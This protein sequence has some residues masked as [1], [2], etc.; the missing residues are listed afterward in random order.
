M[1]ILKIIHLGGI[2][3]DY[4][5]LIGFIFLYFY[6]FVAIYSQLINKDYTMVVFATFFLFVFTTGFICQAH[7]SWK[8]YKNIYHVKGIEGLNEIED[9]KIENITKSKIRLQKFFFSLYPS[10]IKIIF[11]PLCLFNI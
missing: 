8:N 9:K 5:L 4:F 6:N 1:K 3:G 10:I 11:F 7:S 2:E